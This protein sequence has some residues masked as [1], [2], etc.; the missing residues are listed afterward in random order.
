[1]Y[2]TDVD[3]F[4]REIPVKNAILELRRVTYSYPTGEVPTLNNMDLKIFPGEKVA[5]LGN[6]GAGKSTLFLI[7]NGLI[8]PD[9]G[10]IMMDNKILTTSKSDIQKIR[11]S[12]GLVFQDPDKMFIAPTVMGEVSFGL[13]NMGL[14]EDEVEKI[15]D[16][17]L[18]L[19]NI[20]HLKYRAPHNLSGGEKKLVSIASILA[21]KPKIILFDEPTAG[22]DPEN[23]ENLKDVF[24]IL[25]NEG[26]TL[27]MSTHDM[28]YAWE[29][30]DRAIILSNGII[31]GDGR[32]GEIMTDKKLLYMSGLKE[33]VVPRICKSIF[34][35]NAVDVRTLEELENLI[36]GT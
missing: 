25:E 19:L 6:N 16:E 8:H 32:R 30:A 29:F 9:K 12:V 26:I 24:K 22:L 1:M 17:T 3:Y 27:I 34:K 18:Q 33:P 31:V 20:E 10:E 28:D 21:M 11:N 35:E 4:R 7:L 23:S 14:G 5:L 13:F 2:D 15:V 36:E